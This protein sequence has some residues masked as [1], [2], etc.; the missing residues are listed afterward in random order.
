[1]SEAVS[2]QKT[3]TLPIDEIMMEVQDR[4]GGKW[5]SAE[6]IGSFIRSLNLVLKDLMNRNK[7]LFSIEQ[8]TISVSASAPTITF[9][10]GTVQIFNPVVRVSGTDYPLTAVS[11]RDFQTIARKE[12]YGRPMQYTT[13][14]TRDNL[15]MRLWPVP[16]ANATRQIVYYAVEDPDDVTKL[17]Q[18]PD[19][20][21][22]FLPVLIAGTTYY[23]SMKKGPNFPTDRI[24]MFKGEY[25]QQIGI[26]FAED[27]E[28]VSHV[29]VPI[30]PNPY[31]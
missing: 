4:L 16:D 7:P 28:L 11:F 21:R 5:S 26:T 19:L 2:G 13:E 23:M 24:N 17:Y 10:S 18:L 30:I 14:Q 6:E 3:W 1:M 27:R 8:K 22:R 25:E 15:I 31:N 20:H 12:T 9:S 29:V